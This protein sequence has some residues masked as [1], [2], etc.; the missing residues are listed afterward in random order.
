MLAEDEHKH[1]EKPLARKTLMTKDGKVVTKELARK[2]MHD[3][4]TKL[5]TK[6]ELFTVVTW[7]Q[8]F[9]WFPVISSIYFVIAFIIFYLFFAFVL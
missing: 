6:I 9:R 8:R 7:T 4:N 1:R 3:K 5:S 2:I